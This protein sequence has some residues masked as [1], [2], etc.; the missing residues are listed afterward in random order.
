[1]SDPS[2]PAILLAEDSEDHVFLFKRA[3]RQSGSEHELHVVSDGV[4]AIEY[5][6]REGSYSEAI[7]PEL[8]VLDINMPRMNGF[9][10]LDVIKGDDHFNSIPV[11]ILTSSVQEEDVSRSYS[12]G[13]CTF[14]SKPISFEDFCRMV[15]DFSKYWTSVA[16]LPPI[17]D[18]G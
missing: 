14:V 10:T 5:L 13:A 3:L 1:M 2:L 16:T 7:R 12:G 4:E 18:R 9:E 17:P 11:V 8:I 6:R 15:G